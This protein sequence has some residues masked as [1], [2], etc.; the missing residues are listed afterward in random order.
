MSLY[1]VF[2]IGFIAG[3][4]LGM[5]ALGSYKRTLQMKAESGTNQSECI[6]GKWYRITKEESE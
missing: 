6:N 1:Y 3:S 4:L 5:V 2:C